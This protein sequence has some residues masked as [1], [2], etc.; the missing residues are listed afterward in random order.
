MEEQN[1]TSIVAGLTL[2]VDR[3]T[4]TGLHEATII[5]TAGNGYETG[6]RYAIYLAAGTV[7]STSVAGEIV[8]AF[9]VEASSAVANS[10]YG[11]AVLKTETAAILEDTGTTLDGRIPAALVGGRIDATVDGTGME[12]G[13][14]DAIWDEAQ[15]ETTGAPAIT[16]TMR[17]FMQWWA[18]LSRNKMTQ[19]A[20]TSTLFDD[21]GTTS[22]ATSVVSDDA[23]TFTRNEWST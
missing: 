12:A 1:T 19:D 5:A 23:T 17:A 6:K 21:T 14:V 13:A 22:L 15:V 16:G 11:L 10:T 4:V 3:A 18:A 20:T 7:S 2:N 8:G 9:S